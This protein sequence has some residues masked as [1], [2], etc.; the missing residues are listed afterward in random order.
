VVTEETGGRVLRLPRDADGA[1][2][3]ARL[4]SLPAGVHNKE[5]PWSCYDASPHDPP[6]HIVRPTTG[7]GLEYHEQVWRG[8]LVSVTEA[9]AV[10]KERLEKGIR[11]KELLN[12]A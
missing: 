8:I 11:E 3:I 1:E 4:T 7:E 9:S 5:S 12:L 10:H 2:I 6:D